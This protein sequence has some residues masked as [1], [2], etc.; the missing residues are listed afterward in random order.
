MIDA[1]KDPLTL[2]VPMLE[3]P[4]Q[5]TETREM[6]EEKLGE[7][8][9]Q[10]GC[11]S[12]SPYRPFQE[13]ASDQVA[14]IA[15]ANPEGRKLHI[16]SNS[17][18]YHE[19]TYFYVEYF[20]SMLDELV[21]VHIDQH[22]DAY[23]DEEDYE[24]KRFQRMRDP[25]K[26]YYPQFTLGTFVHYIKALPQVKSTIML[27]YVSGSWHNNYNP[28]NSYR[29]VFGPAGMIKP[30]DLE[31]VR[32]KNVYISIDADSQLGWHGFMMG[33]QM[34]YQNLKMSLEGIGS[35][36]NVVGIDMTGFCKTRKE[37]EDLEKGD[38]PYTDKEQFK[39]TKLVFDLTR[40]VLK[41]KQ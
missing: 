20:A 32:G 8:F 11:S 3:H 28:F 40:D 22:P 5:V 18:R 9:L 26:P 36:A 13:K 14:F 34:P 15:K 31:L 17:N 35:V 39:I 37:F 16:V 12:R 2:F 23:M 33:G 1:T 19:A 21:Y 27:G 29:K 30:E 25:S 7:K 38:Y 10:L 41:R 6:L 4:G 24:M